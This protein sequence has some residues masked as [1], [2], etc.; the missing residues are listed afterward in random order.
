MI[1]ERNIREK[2]LPTS[3]PVTLAWGAHQEQG[4]VEDVSR[5]GAF[6]QTKANVVAGEV[7]SLT[8]HAEE[9]VTVPCR[10]AH[11]LIQETANQLGR[12]IGLGVQFLPSPAL[13][14]LENLLAQPEDEVPV[15][16]KIRVSVFGDKQIIRE[17]LG[18]AL[19]G[20]GYSVATFGDEKELITRCLRGDVDIVVACLEA[21][22]LKLLETYGNAATLRTIPMIALSDGFDSVTRLQALQC[23]VD[24][25]I[26]MPFIDAELIFR[27]DRIRDSLH[28][29]P[30]AILQ[31]DLREI[32][33]AALLSILDAERKMGILW[34]SRAGMNHKLYVREGKVLSV[35]G[36]SGDELELL[37]ALLGWQ[38][39][40]FEFNSCSVTVEDK[41]NLSL[42]QLL[43]EH[44]YR[45]DTK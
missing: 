2:R 27:L 15:G 12:S 37:M 33:L 38:D 4:V 28:L 1:R 10:V 35:G 9:D 41:I 3:F 13:S 18:L 34:V 20:A 21:D 42:Q 14:A 22:N 43:L 31:G 7:L 6:V 25:F 8:I 11:V 30:G 23:G 44:A 17:R 36:G 19:L 5:S 32:G 45:S 26:P 39:G 29:I 24:D 40:S 16:N